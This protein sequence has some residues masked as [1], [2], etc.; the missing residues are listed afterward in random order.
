[1]LGRCCARAAAPLKHLKTYLSAS[2]EPHERHP[3]ALAQDLLLVVRIRAQHLDGLWR[4]DGA[5][6]LGSLV[7]YL[8]PRARGDPLGGARGGNPRPSEAIRAISGNRR[9][10]AAIRGHPRRQLAPIN[11]NQRQSASIKGNQRTMPCSSSRRTASHRASSASA[12][13]REVSIEKAGRRQFRR[14]ALGRRSARRG[15]GRERRDRHVAES[16]AEADRQHCT[17]DRTALGGQQPSKSLS[18]PPSPPPSP[19]PSRPRGKI[20]RSTRAGPEAIRS[21]QEAIRTHRSARAGRGR[22]RSRA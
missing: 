2:L 14:A 3:A 15:A 21:N 9:W 8:R 7:A 18:K 19:R 20:H 5:K 4:A 10:S 17:A 16:G 1:M 22:R 11:G 13:H 6:R 12:Q